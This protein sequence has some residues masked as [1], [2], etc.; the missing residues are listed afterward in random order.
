VFGTSPHLRST[1]ASG[2]VPRGRGFVP[3][4]EQSVPIASAEATRRPGRSGIGARDT[5]VLKIDLSHDP[6]PVSELASVFSAVEMLVAGAA[7][8]YICSAEDEVTRRFRD[9]LRDRAMHHTA[10]DRLLLWNALFASSPMS[11][12]RRGQRPRASVDSWNDASD[13]FYADWLRRELLQDPGAF[14]MYMGYARVVR[15][16][17]R[18]PAHIRVALGGF[19]A[20]VAG[21][22]VPLGVPT[23][24]SVVVLAVALIQVALGLRAQ[25]LE[26]KRD[27][28][29]TKRIIAE[30]ALRT[31]I[32]ERTM[33]DLELS[34]EVRELAVRAA[35][36]G[37]TGLQG[38]II[39]RADLIE[40]QGQEQGQG[41]GGL[42]GPDGA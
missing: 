34:D 15:L 28:A 1:P 14:E 31:V 12:Q 22:A 24:E 35:M 41:P 8:P 19:T 7:W 38:G 10:A 33:T 27:E 40:P 32:V 17:R 25:W 18:S 30:E 21:V 26:L 42:V 36:P 9:Q 13:T 39:R 11:H 3:R 6:A 5:F 23:P 29:V 37:L 20:S 16:Q 4:L 2:R